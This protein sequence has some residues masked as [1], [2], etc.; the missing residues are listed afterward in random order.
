MDL[1]RFRQ[2]ASAFRFYAL[3]VGLL[4]GMLFIGYQLATFQQAENRQQTA[5][6]SGSLAH[7][8]AENHRLN[9]A[10]SQLDVDI[11]VQHSAQ[12]IAEQSML[13]LLEENQALQQKIQ[14]YQL[15]LGE[16][17]KAGPFAIHQLQLH[18]LPEQR[19]YLLDLLLLQGRAL[20]SVINGT[21]NITIEGIV[22]D[23]ATTL[24]LPTLFSG[25]VFIENTDESM[26]YRYQYFLEKQYV[27]QLPEGFVAN[28]ITISTDVYQWKRKID[29]FT[30]T[31]LWADLIAPNT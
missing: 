2:S 24:A 15:V 11:A 20:K 29:S 31:V 7:A 4:I 14:L 23:Q 12:K 10:L 27:I 26:R 16:N 22:A 13:E 8:Q 28:S 19:H 6:L 1:Y 21:L 3:I 18:R 5:Q 25:S 17:E 9:Q 30:Q